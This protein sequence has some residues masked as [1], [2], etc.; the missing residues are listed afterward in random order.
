[1]GNPPAAPAIPTKPGTTGQ[2]V[3]WGTLTL[4]LSN[5][6]TLLKV[7]KDVLEGLGQLK[8]FAPQIMPLW[9]I[10]V[11]VGLA[12]LIGN[13]LLFRFLFDKIKSRILPGRTVAAG[14]VAAVAISL[15]IVTNVYSATRLRADPSIAEER[16]LS[17][18]TLAQADGSIAGFRIYAYKPQ[19]KEDSWTTAQ[20]ITAI[21]SVSD[22]P[23]AGRLK[24]A[25]AYLESKHLKNGWNADPNG[26]NS[27]IRTEISC[28]VAIAYFTSLRKT[29][30][31]TPNESIAVSKRAGDILRQVVAQQ[32]GTGA[33][34]PVVRPA[35]ENDRTYPTVMALWALLEA[36][37]ASNIPQEEKITFGNAFDK[38]VLWL[39]E[40]YRIGY[41][42]DENPAIQS[43][44][45]FDGLNYEALLLLKRAE[46]LGGYNLF[47]DEEGYKSI[48]HDVVN[49]FPTPVE[50]FIKTQIP[51]SDYGVDGEICWATFPSYPW[52]L[53]AL[54]YLVDD[55]DISSSDQ[56]K[57]RKILQQ[58]IE[59]LNDLPAYLKTAETWE[60]AEN[61]IG[62]SYEVH[63][64]GVTGK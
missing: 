27:F 33:W 62:L 64:A 4:A 34:G 36:L 20:V 12:V 44:A 5:T 57:L 55:K 17:E 42:W 52:S 61:L 39:L 23:D 28:W 25:F 19:E 15:L 46:D 9:L 13:I 6:A 1:M 32:D 3:L 50:V 63:K 30:F 49:L 2:K 59:K 10:E 24:A 31:W 35:Q 21:I 7:L 29:G 38:G 51:P 54:S 45:R 53:A 48:K 22:R 37:S 16:L 11:L 18:A 43:G 56:R 8:S 40:K 60:L 26:K 14:A 47:K 41:G 58:E